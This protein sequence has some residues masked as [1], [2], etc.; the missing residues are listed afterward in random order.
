MHISFV[1]NHLRY[2]VTS[3]LSGLGAMTLVPQR[4][5]KPGGGISVRVYRRYKVE[6]G[7]KSQTR[8]AGRIYVLNIQAFNTP[9]V[10]MMLYF[11]CDFCDIC[12]DV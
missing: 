5:R 7:I 8:Y 6:C 1:D 9:R 2:R 3:V 11:L 10:F 4:Q 12:V